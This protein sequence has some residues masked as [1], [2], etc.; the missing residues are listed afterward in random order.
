MPA[1]LKGDRPMTTSERTA[2]WW[3]SIK[4]DKVAHEEY[5]R[6]RRVD[7]INIAFY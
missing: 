6:R 2:E 5:K 4:S 1:K 7:K 3:S